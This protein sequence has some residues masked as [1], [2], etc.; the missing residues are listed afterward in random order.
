MIRDALKGLATIL[1]LV[2][3]VG[4]IVLGITASAKRA[5]EQT[6]HE[7]A[8]KNTAVFGEKHEYSDFVLKRGSS[9][10]ISSEVGEILLCLPPDGRPAI[11][12]SEKHEE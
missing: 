1:F 8:V 10:R 5:S 3:V 4:C 2:I 11:L 7:T 12:V 6:S 9:L